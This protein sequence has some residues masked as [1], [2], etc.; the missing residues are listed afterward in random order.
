MSAIYLISYKIKQ[1]WAF[2]LQIVNA[3]NAFA[4]C[5][6]R[7][8]RT[9]A[10]APFLRSG[11]FDKLNHRHF[12]TPAAVLQSLTHRLRIK[13]FTNIQ[14]IPFFYNAKWICLIKRQLQPPLPLFPGSQRAYKT[15]VSVQSQPELPALI[16]ELMKTHCSF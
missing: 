6:G 11:G 14:K 1:F 7:A 9:S 4:I 3:K 13:L 12:G 16:Q 2:P 10:L 15:S 5:K 8:L